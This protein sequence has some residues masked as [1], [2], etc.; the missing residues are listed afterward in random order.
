MYRDNDD[1]WRARYEIRRSELMMHVHVVATNRRMT[2]V[3]YVGTCL[4]NG[5]VCRK[6]SAFA[7]EA[8]NVRVCKR[9]S[10]VCKRVA[11]ANT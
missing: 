8:Q 11:Y 9:D 6:K 5:G 2:L 10:L 7:N 3:L 1:V 4:Q